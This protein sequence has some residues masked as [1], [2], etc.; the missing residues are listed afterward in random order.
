[1]T[2]LFDS[3]GNIKKYIRQWATTRTQNDFVGFNDNG[4]LGWYRSS[5]YFCVHSTSSPISIKQGLFG[6]YIGADN[7]GGGGTSDGPSGRD[8]SDVTFRPVIWN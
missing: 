1:M 8:F 4:T 5:D 7:L 3:N 2:G 6:I